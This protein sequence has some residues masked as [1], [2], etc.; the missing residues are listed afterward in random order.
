MNRYPALPTTLFGLVLAGALAN[1]R[2][3]VAHRGRFWGHLPREHR[4]STGK[5]NVSHSTTASC[6]ALACP[7]VW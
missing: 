2:T 6:R 3:L 7:A 1:A 4:L 5:R